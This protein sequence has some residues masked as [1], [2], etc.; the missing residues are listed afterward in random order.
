MAVEEPDTL[1][2][3]NVPSVP[4]DS[5]DNSDSSVEILDSGSD[6]DICEET[7]LARFSR[8]LR[9]AQ[10]KALAE[11]NVKGKKRKTFSGKSWT[12]AYR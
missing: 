6:T 1:D 8:I 5:D 2:T 9:D 10:I 12:T 7:E 4:S 11:E 3:S